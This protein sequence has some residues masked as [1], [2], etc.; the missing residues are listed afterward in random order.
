[1][2]GTSHPQIAKIWRDFHAFHDEELYTSFVEKHFGQTPANP[3]DPVQDYKDPEYRSK[4]VEETLD[5]FF[6]IDSA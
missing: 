6:K 5:N 1:M 4:F 3:F 2:T